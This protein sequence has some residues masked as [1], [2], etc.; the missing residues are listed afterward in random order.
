MLA[1]FSII[2]GSDSDWPEH[3]EQLG[4]PLTSESIDRIIDLMLQHNPNLSRQKIEIVL[5]RLGDLLVER[6]ER[7]QSI[8]TK[9]F[10]VRPSSKGYFADGEFYLD[11]ERILS[12]HLV[13]NQQMNF[14]QKDPVPYTR[15]QTPQL[16]YFDDLGSK[17]T[18]LL[19]TPGGL[20]ELRGAH[21]K[22]NKL[23]LEHGLFFVGED[24][25]EFRVDILAVVNPEKL[26][27]VIPSPMPGGLYFL[28]LK[29]RG[30]DKDIVGELGNTLE[31]EA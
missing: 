3:K 15:L 13:L 31:V 27:F 20:A 4:L 17:T 1:G 25:S 29:V 14:L 9:A 12:F 26:F 8:T 19:I 16:E 21:F 7:G 23:D 24:Q 2:L 22:C 28:K 5:S 11:P 6:I 18:N 10:S 30:M